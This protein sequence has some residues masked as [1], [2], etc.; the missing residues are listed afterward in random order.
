MSKVLV[1]GA[2]GFIGRH[3]LPLLSAAGF[4]VHAVSGRNSQHSPGVCWHLADLL[5][6]ERQRALLEEVRP[7][8]LLHLAWYVPP[9]Q[10]WTAT[11]NIAWQRASLELL[12]NFSSV[13]G[14]R[15]V[16]AGTCYEYDWSTGGDWKETDATGP[17]MLY[18]TCKSA[19]QQ[20]AME[21]GRA[22]GVEVAWGRIFYPYGPG[23][24]DGRLI[25]FV[26]GSLMEGKPARCTEGVQVRDFIFVEDV[27]RALALLVSSD[28]TGVVNIASGMTARVREVVS[29][30]G[31]Q[32]NRSELIELGAIPTRTFEPPRLTANV[33]RLRSLG[34]Q[35]DFTIQQGLAR[36]I[37][38]WASH[39]S[40][41]HQR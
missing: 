20:T 13:G 17:S 35:P 12:E 9:N 7:S 10:F 22:L 39:R 36:T 1:T 6:S 34:F 38:W 40:A 2:S 21:M 3:V 28:F 4:T 11:E 5:S 25:P 37:E 41:D 18:G 8:H 23:E 29:E 32:M 31:R 30:I 19:T 15:W 27:A 26:I 24:P 16:G 33:E 14:K